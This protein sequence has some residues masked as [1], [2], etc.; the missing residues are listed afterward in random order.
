MKVNLNGVPQ[1]LTIY[2]QWVM[3]R[4]EQQ[5]AETKP[6]KVPY[7]AITGMKASVTD[8]STW[9]TFATCVSRLDSYDGI[10]FVLTASDPFVVF[11][12]DNPQGEDATKFQKYYGLLN[13]FTEISPS[14]QGCH[15]WIKAQLPSG[16][17]SRPFEIYSE[18][19]F[20]TVTGNVYYNCEIANR[21][22]EAYTIYDELGKGRNFYQFHD[23]SAPQTETDR[24]IYDKAAEARNGAKFLDLWNGDFLKHYP[25][26][27]EA[28]FALTDII[29]FYTQNLEQI[30]RLFR[31]SALGRR[32]KA[33]RDDYVTLMANKAF[34]KLP[35]SLNLDEI[36]SVQAAAIAQYKQ[37]QEQT[38][39][40]DQQQSKITAPT[41]M[42]Y[43][44][45]D[46]GEMQTTYTDTNTFVP[47][48][49]QTLNS[50]HKH[51]DW[52]QATANQI[53]DAP[54]DFPQGMVGDMA[55]FIYDSA[56]RPVREI[57]IT[58]ALGL[59]AGICGS[60][61]NIS[62][63]GLNLY[64]MM[65]AGTGTGKEALSTGINKLMTRLAAGVPSARNFIGA[66][67]VASPQ[68][69][70]ASLA[71]NRC[72]VSI[73]GE[74]G[75]WMRTLSDPYAP[76]HILGQRR[77][78][79]E[80]YGRSG[81]D[82]E[83]QPSIYADKAKNLKSIKQPAYSILAESTQT[84]FF[85]NVNASLIAEGFIPRW[86]IVEYK[87]KRVPMN[88]DH[89]KVAPSPVL[90]TTMATMV[91]HVNDMMEAFLVTNVE[92]MNDD[93]KE[94][95]R[96]FN[97]YCDK[98]HN[99]ADDEAIKDIWTRA[100]MKALR[101]AALLAVGKNVVNPRIDA[102]D[103]E[104]SKFIV[105]KDV[106]SLCRHVQS[107]F[108]AFQQDNETL[109]REKATYRLL[110]EYALSEYVPN[111]EK[112]YGITADM[113]AKHAFSHTFLARKLYNRKEFKKT[114]SFKSPANLVQE[115][116]QE[117]SNCGIIRMLSTQQAIQ[118]FQT[119]G[120]VYVINDVEKVIN[121]FD[122]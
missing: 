19:R 56:P 99:D 114:K 4:Y 52:M 97:V 9:N 60:A 30:I 68:A 53:I 72:C 90:L 1:E 43:P 34:D 64:I 115:C 69:L 116:V 121:R 16:R 71:E 24:E 23:G 46:E 61:Y 79:L 78:Y 31:M 5:N 57:A 82:A 62:G 13:S 92:M 49:E 65:L 39:Q 45:D 38:T 102:A 122:N 50:A 80:L 47:S 91:K 106:M 3:W 44:V 51:I 77:L 89:D 26:Q 81:K 58:S 98:Q 17:N 113:K 117:L 54:L 40:Y 48:N 94:N 27:S 29:A 35:P 87:G 112:S 75:L 96:A 12:A 20:I 108:G 93:V 33:Q 70:M 103:W 21:Q 95:V 37:Q 110:K 120:K 2:R 104:W 76:A 85:E 66:A 10:G 109:E 101:V 14:K 67:H 18:K 63:S 7:N 88:E 107:G 55:R 118:E 73:I 25:S 111:M 28:D 74:A 15:V 22:Q 59:M 84:R 100:Y 42:H 8:A 86:L 119:S 11:D 83:L 32:E 6:T 105:L 41:A 36:A